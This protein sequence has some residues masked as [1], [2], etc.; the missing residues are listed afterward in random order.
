MTYRVELDIYNGP[1]DLL[2]YLVR[3]EEVEV[4][5]I[6]VA[7]V[8]EQYV[9]YMELLQALDI[10][11]AGEFLV[12]A[13][14]LV[15]LKSRV[16]LPRP[17]AIED[18]DSPDEDEGDPRL[19]LIQQLLEYKR[20]KDAADD[21]AVLGDEQSRRYGRPAAEM[22]V[23]P[24]EQRFALDDL[25]KDVEL[26]DL[27]NA[28]ARVMRSINIA[29][30]EVVYDDTPIEDIAE[31]IVEIVRARQTVLFSELFARLFEDVDEIG[32]GHL[33]GAFLAVLE[34]IRQ[35]LILFEQDR[36]FGDLRIHWRPETGDEPAPSRKRRARRGVRITSRSKA[37][38]AKGIATHEGRLKRSEY[39]FDADDIQATEFDDELHAIV[40]PEIRRYKHIYTD[41]ELMGRPES[42]A[43]T[44]PGDPDEQPT[45]DDAPAAPGDEVGEQPPPDAGGPAEETSPHAA[46]PEDEPPPDADAA[47]ETPDETAPDR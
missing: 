7:R 29:P 42:D 31:Q 12:M 9:A 21:L 20:F 46:G 11:V 28:F 38:K 40:V 19:E 34:C 14:T 27:L 16:L 25:M 26:W 33:V 36:D 41:D 30:R 23:G 45:G 43:E 37:R 18:E 8:A 2:L 22:V 13:A 35:R 17:E 32:R 10:N 24:D 39:D 5:D 4:T 47:A 15:E 1:L 6:P 44:D 3:K